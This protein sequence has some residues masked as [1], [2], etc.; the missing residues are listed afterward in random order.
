MAMHLFIVNK[1][2]LPIH[3]KYGFVGVTL[4]QKGNGE[5]REDSSW[6][7]VKIDAN[8]ENVQAGV[9]ADICRVYKGDSI[10]F[11]LEAIGKD[12]DRDREGGRFFGTFSVKSF[13]PFYE[14]SG[15]YLCSHLGRPLVYRMLIEPETVYRRGLSEWQLMDEMSGFRTILDVPWTLIYRKLRGK[16]GCTPLLPHEEQVIRKLLDLNNLGQVL[17]DTAYSFDLETLN[18]TGSCEGAKYAGNV[19]T[20]FSVY[21]RACHLMNNTTRKWEVY[22]QA[23]LMESIRR[24]QELTERLFPN[25]E[26]FWVG[27][28]VRC[29]AGLQSIDI[30]VFSRND[31]NTFLHLVELKTQ[32]ADS[33]TAAQLNRYIKWLKAHIPN[34]S[35]GQIIPTIVAPDVRKEFHS[36]LVNFLRGHGIAYY[37]EILFD[38]N[39][40]FHQ[41]YVQVT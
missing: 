14:P 36:E 23:Y 13:R 37:S 20:F 31:H 12:Y 10:L 5:W 21:N 9:Y 1:D 30:L 33:I 15:E 34:I 4:G 40:S 28:E 32:P 3:L 39:L 35:F 41:R 7:D 22:L 2:T 26:V 24:N 25:V 38:S 6:Q 18:L 8:S 29:G 16:R 17:T 11:Y 19:S 27:N